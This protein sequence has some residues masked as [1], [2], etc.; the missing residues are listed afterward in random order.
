MFVCLGYS[1]STV[2]VDSADLVL[3]AGGC[4]AIT[5]ALETYGYNKQL[6]CH[7]GDII[8]ML[9]N[10]PNCQVWP[11]CFLT[12]GLLRKRLCFDCVARVL[13]GWLPQARFS[14]NKGLT[15]IMAG[16]AE[17]PKDDLVQLRY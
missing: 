6:M 8:A 14:S 15:L 7:A 9:G 2:T 17:H 13:F 5:S 16:M 4:E 1:N 3:A 10:N 11:W 12:L